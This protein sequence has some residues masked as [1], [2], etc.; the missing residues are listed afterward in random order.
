MRSD[1]T[2]YGLAIILFIVAIASYVLIA[3]QNLKIVSA[4]I[5]AIIGAVLAVAG[6]LLKP[7][8]QVAASSSAP[9]ATQ[10]PPVD[11][12]AQATVENQLVA[13][14]IETESSQMAEIKTEKTVI[15]EA[16]AETPATTPEPAI[17]TNETM[18]VTETEAVTPIASEMPKMGLTQVKGIGEKRANQLKA[19]G[20]SSI[21]DL[22]KA[23]VA[24]LA[25]KLKVSPKIVEKW[26]AGA[27]D[28]TK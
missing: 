3:E 9:S 18:A 16:S 19:N 14:P 6:F 8:V 25:S 2:L 28:L 24:A 26:V 17:P 5:L 1:Y 10:E 15:S 11:Q 4:I 22:A 27:K 21:D 13:T 23:D 7:K 12:S 20:I